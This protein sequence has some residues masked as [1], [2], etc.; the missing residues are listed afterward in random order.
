[1]IWT[2]VD[3]ILMQEYNIDIRV[4]ETDVLFGYDHADVLQNTF[5]N[6]IISVTKLSISKFRYGRYPNIICLLYS[7]LRIQNLLKI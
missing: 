2:E 1:M 6:N 3:K 5:I 4:T 7:E